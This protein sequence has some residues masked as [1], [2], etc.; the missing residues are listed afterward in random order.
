MW[1][2]ASSSG[3]PSPALARSAEARHPCL[4]QLAGMPIPEEIRAW[5]TLIPAS[6]FDQ[7]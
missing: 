2:S 4:M 1:K 7:G 3:A 6:V 5:M